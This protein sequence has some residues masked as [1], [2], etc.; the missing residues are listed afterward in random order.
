MA[1]GEPARYERREYVPG[2]CV[3]SNRGMFYGMVFMNDS[4][5]SFTIDEKVT[6]HEIPLIQ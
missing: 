5:A 6:F 1:A 2:K 4:D 3:R